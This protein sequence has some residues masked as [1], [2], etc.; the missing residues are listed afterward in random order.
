MLGLDCC[1]NNNVYQ[2][3]L[4]VTSNV[5]TFMFYIS[6][7][8]SFVVLFGNNF[9]NKMKKQQIT[10]VV[11]LGLFV[12]SNFLLVTACNTL[13]NSKGSDYCNHARPYIVDGSKIK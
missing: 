11:L 5:L 3:Y 8:S 12:V 7:F 13:A 9:F 4:S 10:Y 6:L 2:L 1:T